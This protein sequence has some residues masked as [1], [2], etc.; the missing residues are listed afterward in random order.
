[1]KHDKALYWKELSG[2]TTKWDQILQCC[3]KKQSVVI[4]ILRNTRLGINVI[5]TSYIMYSQATV[6]FVREIVSIINV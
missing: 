3:Q 6:L 2:F 5:H 4:F 1:M